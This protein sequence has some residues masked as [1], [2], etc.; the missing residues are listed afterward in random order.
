M[1]DKNVLTHIDAAMSKL[2][3]LTSIFEADADVSMC[4]DGILYVINGIGHD[5]GA[6]YEIE[7]IE[8]KP[9]FSQVV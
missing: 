8:D 2:Q 1:A 6:I 3:L 9:A 7:T 4:N 5:L